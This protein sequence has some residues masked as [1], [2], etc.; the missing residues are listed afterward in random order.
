MDVIEVSRNRPANKGLNMSERRKI[1]KGMLATGICA[2]F[3]VR[4]SSLLMP[5]KDRSLIT[6]EVR[7]EQLAEN[8]GPL[9]E[10][11]WLQTMRFQVPT[12]RVNFETPNELLATAKR[13]RPEVYWS[14]LIIVS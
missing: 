3:V 9:P 7:G 10:P 12:K 6:Y 14:G 2:P 1:L 13:I 4:N 5:V 11:D 8:G